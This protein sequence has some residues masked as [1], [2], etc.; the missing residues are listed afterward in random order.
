MKFSKWQGLG[1]HYVIVERT[2]WPV[3]ID[4]AVARLV[5]DPYRGVGGD[6]IL[7]IAFEGQT[8]RMIVWNPDGSNAESCG[9]GIRMVTKYLDRAGALPRDGIILTGGGPVHAEVLEDA[10]V[11]VE[12]GPARFPAGERTEMLAVAGTSVEFIE[13]SMGNPHAVIVHPDPESVV[14][15]LGPVIEVDPRFPNR[16]NVE[17]IRAD[18][19]GEITMR[20]WER[21]VGETMA[22]GT[23]ACAAAVAAVR[24]S[25]VA[26]P[27][28]VHLLGGDLVIDVNEEDL[29]VTMT[30]GA[31]P[32]FEGTLS[33]AFRRCLEV[34][35]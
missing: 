22:C 8:P 3:E 13:V 23:G 16:T 17:F 21:G 15:A 7:E 32:I 6:G 11:R 35:Q 24:L 19:P 29:S 2:D 1:N 20:V 10:R 31:E 34:A 9:N 5:C 25:G 14:Q 33:D 30:G 4:A 27:V 26:S 28:T 12:M 18:G